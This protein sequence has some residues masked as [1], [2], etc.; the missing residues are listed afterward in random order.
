MAMAH[1]ASSCSLSPGPVQALCLGVTTAAEC[2]HGSALEIAADKV[3]GVSPI[4]QPMEPEC[5]L[6]RDLRG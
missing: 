3:L 1:A 5:A 4:P 6:C 2:Y